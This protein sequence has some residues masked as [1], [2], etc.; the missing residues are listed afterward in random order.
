M[1]RTSMYVVKRDR[2][3]DDFVSNISIVTWKRILLS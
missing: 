3:D 1:R 2:G